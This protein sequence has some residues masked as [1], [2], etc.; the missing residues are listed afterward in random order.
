[1]LFRLCRC[2]SGDEEIAPGKLVT[3][4]SA[5]LDWAGSTASS[6]IYIYGA[7]RRAR[8]SSLL[9]IWQGLES[10]NFRAGKAR[11]PNATSRVQPRAN[12]CP[13]ILI[14]FARLL[15]MLFLFCANSSAIRLPWGGG[16][17]GEGRRLGGWLQRGGG[18]ERER[19]RLGSSTDL[20]PPA[21]RGARESACVIAIKFILEETLVMLNF[22]EIE[23]LDVFLSLNKAAGVT[24]ITMKYIFIVR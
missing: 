6:L 20:A 8:A 14:K 18:G 19:D 13:V 16:S 23:E 3:L 15:P 24:N 21:A 7:I 17:V 2:R 5:C 11:L 10:S 9:V 1:V 12:V 4:C 22:R